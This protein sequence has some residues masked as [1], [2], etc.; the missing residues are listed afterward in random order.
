MKKRFILLAAA[1]MAVGGAWARTLSPSEALGR[2]ISSSE[3]PTSVAAM[4]APGHVEAALTL[5]A[6]ATG[7]PT[8]YVIS[9][10]EQSGF[11]AVAADDVAAPVLGYSDEGSASDLNPNVRYWLDELSREI[12]AA[13]AAGAP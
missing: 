8:L 2:A 9:R 1:A 5:S 6:E 7:T 11:I 10:G 3:A 13:V 4:R 12:S